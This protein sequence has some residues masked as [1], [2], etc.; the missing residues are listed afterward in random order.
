MDSG[1]SAHA[2]GRSRLAAEEAFARDRLGEAVDAGRGDDDL[3]FNVYGVGVGEGCS[4]RTI[5]CCSWVVVVSM[6]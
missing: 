3:L 2:T 6:G 5:S 4:T 1:F